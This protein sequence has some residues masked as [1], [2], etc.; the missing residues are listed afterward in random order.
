[1]LEVEEA[2]PVYSALGYIYGLKGEFDKALDLFEKFFSEAD[3][4]FH[5]D[6]VS[7]DRLQLPSSTWYQLYKWF[8][9]TS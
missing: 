3:Y 6:R 5:E 4:H 1:M 8:F 2:N 7:L 9:Q